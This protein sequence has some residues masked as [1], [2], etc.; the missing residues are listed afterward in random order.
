M[1]DG[2]TRNTVRERS[3]EK[4]SQSM[5]AIRGKRKDDGRIKINVRR[6]DPNTGY[7]MYRMYST[8][9]ADGRNSFDCFKPFFRFSRFRRTLRVRQTQ[10]IENRKVKG[11]GLSIGRC[12]SQQKIQ[13]R[14][15]MGRPIQ[16]T[17][18]IHIAKK[19]AQRKRRKDLKQKKTPG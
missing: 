16:F 13:R 17:D 11:E 2:D 10:K 6:P 3:D 8:I 7:S 12:Q 19:E 1:S 9:K 4:M 5:K 18:P 15:N 14:R